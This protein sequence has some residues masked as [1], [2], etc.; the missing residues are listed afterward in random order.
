MRAQRHAFADRG[1][2]LTEAQRK[3][4]LTTAAAVA[5]IVLFP[6]ASIA[7]KTLFS[8]IAGTLIV[9]GLVFLAKS[10]VEPKTK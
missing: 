2:N 5:L 4:L 10:K 6:P 8:Q 3:V 1:G 7:I 9:C